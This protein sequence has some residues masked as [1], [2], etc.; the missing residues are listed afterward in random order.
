MAALQIVRDTIH[1]SFSMMNVGSWDSLGWWPHKYLLLQDFLTIRGRQ[2]GYK[3]L[4]MT[5]EVFV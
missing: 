1:L 2:Q 3:D 5:T 4:G